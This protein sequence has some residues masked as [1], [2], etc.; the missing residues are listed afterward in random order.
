VGQFF[1]NTP[2][3]PVGL[4]IVYLGGLDE[5]VACGAGVGILGI[6]REEPIIAAEDTGVH[7]VLHQIRIGGLVNHE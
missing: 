3:V 2:E 1:E 6:T 7:L 5:A 4:Q